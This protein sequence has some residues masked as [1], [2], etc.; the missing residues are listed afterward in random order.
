MPFCDNWC[1]FPKTDQAVAEI[2][3]PFASH[4][5]KIMVKPNEGT[6]TSYNHNFKTVC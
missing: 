1:A 6:K 5:E 3:L 4:A 2:L